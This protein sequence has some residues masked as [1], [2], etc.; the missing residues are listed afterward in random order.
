[1]VAAS[2]RE[3]FWTRI[4]YRTPSPG[5]DTGDV[6]REVLGHQTPLVV[7]TGTSRGGEVNQFSR[8]E[9]GWGGFFCVWYQRT[10]VRYEAFGGRF[11]TTV[12]DGPVIRVLGEDYRRSFWRRW[13]K[14]YGP[15]T[16]FSANGWVGATVSDRSVYAW[17]GWDW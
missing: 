3:V 12:S 9:G 1:M 6:V 5:L 15:A 14:G 17:F 8:L 2:D 11:W 7:V 13:G 4:S 10:D 16:R